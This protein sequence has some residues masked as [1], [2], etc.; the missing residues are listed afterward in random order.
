MSRNDS[1]PVPLALRRE[2][3]ENLFTILHEFTLGEMA[4]PRLD[5]LGDLGIFPSKGGFWATVQALE[6]QFHERTGEHPKTSYD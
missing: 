4:K 6:H 1:E 5:M 3:W 2:E